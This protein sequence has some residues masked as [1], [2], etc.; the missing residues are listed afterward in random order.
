MK[1]K[2]LGI[3]AILNG[4]KTAL[5]VVFPLIT[6]PYVSGILSV[7]SI[8]AYNFSYSIVGYFE[9]FAA[10]GI[11]TYAIREG[12]KIRD[13]YQKI[14]DFASELFT[15][16]VFS[17][18]I[19]YVL[20]FLAV[21]FVPQFQDYT[22][23]ILILSTIIFATTI[24]C[25]WV[26]SIYEEYLYITVRSIAAYVVSL[27]LLFVLVK[28]SQ[29]VVRYAIATAVATGGA[30]LLYLVSRKKY[31]KIRFIKLTKIHWKRH[32]KPILTI[33]GNTVTTTIYVNSDTIILGFLSSDYYVGLY[34]L[35]VKI[36]TVI[37]RMLAAVI[38]VSIS[39]LSNC[40]GNGKIKEFQDTAE[41]VCLALMTL[42][43]PAVVGIIAL[44]RD[45]ILLISNEDY[46]AAQG[47]LIILCFAL[48]FSVF[49]WFFTSC[50]LIPCHK[51][52]KVL[53][54]TI[55]AAAINV[56]MNF[57]LIPHFQHNAAAFTTLVAELVGLIIGIRNAKNIFSLRAVFKEIRAVII[58]CVFIVLICY[59]C[60]V[61]IDI[62]ILRILF[63]IA[64]SVLVYGA[65]L[66]L[67]KHSLALQVLRI[68]KNR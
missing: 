11:S 19:V 67:L 7:N 56:G 2:S 48:I 22:D 57:I 64:F 30:N 66:L 18:F 52:E 21:A 60:A 68:L 14:S 41:K 42:A 36:Y 15:I 28:D 51:E 24:G 6:F 49:N 62:L 27:I 50:I 53:Y 17:T 10:L 23:L 46:L 59:A 37:K 40:W 4:I 31:C 16:N 29:D 45:I 35:P 3:N 55:V 61:F 65:V 26:Y 44:S 33:F 25:E 54:A 47:A 9:L 63:S 34:S 39:R 1:R 32:L 13:D 5:A 58:G 8:G 43:V 20:L 38:T 12:A